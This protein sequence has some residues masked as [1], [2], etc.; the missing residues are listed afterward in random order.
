MRNKTVESS[1]F[2][3][4]NDAHASSAE[5]LENAIVGDG[6]TEQ[7]RG[8]PYLGHHGRPLETEVNRESR[9]GS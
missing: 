9:R 6:L 7:E 2:G 3:L 1:V 4:V 8:F 5:F